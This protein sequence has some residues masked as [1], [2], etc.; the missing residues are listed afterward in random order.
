MFVLFGS[1]TS[2]K[3]GNVS[4]TIYEQQP[5]CNIP[6]QLIYAEAS[7]SEK[8]SKIYCP[9]TRNFKLTEPIEWFKVKEMFLDV[10]MN[11]KINIDFKKR[12][13]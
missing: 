7:G 5:G 1:P 9:T 4:V 3:I 11:Y 6:T 8:D 2:N 13:P 12:I 10:N